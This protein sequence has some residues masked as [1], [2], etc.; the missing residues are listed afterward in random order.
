MGAYGSSTPKRH[1][2]YS[3]SRKISL[4]NLGKLVWDFSSKK[5]QKNKTTTVK[6][7]NGRKQFTG[8]KKKLKE[9]QYLGSLDVVY[10]FHF[11]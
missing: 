7:K 11:L 2:G 6:V 10:C 8:V 5:Y 4:L 3:S 9:S 1:V